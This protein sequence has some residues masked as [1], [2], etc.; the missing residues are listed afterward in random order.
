MKKIYG[1]ARI[2]TPSQSIDRQIRNI[3]AEYPDAVITQ[4]AYS[5]TKID[6]PQWTKLVKQALK[7]AQ[8]HD[9]TIVFDSVSRMSRNAEEGIQQYFEL[10]DAGIRLIFLKERHINTDMYRTAVS[11]SIP[12]TGNEIADIYIEATNKV[13]RL[14]ARNQIIEAF[15]Q[16]AKEVL[17]LHKRTSEGMETARLAGKQIGRIEGSTIVTKK[18]KEMSERIRKMSKDFEGNMKDFEIIEILGIARGT[19]FR[20]KKAMREAN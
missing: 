19:Y 15:A 8:K 20:Y 17:D 11:Q 12:E 10:Y 18:Q 13:I 1:Y 4:E 3:K 16:S 2:S 9:V 6:R 5:G 7:D 14:L